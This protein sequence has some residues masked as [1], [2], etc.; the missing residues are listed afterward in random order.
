MKKALSDTS[1][2]RLSTGFTLVELLITIVLVAILARIVAP[3]MSSF[4]LNTRLTSASYEMTRSIQ[5]ARTEAIKRQSNVVL[6]T[7]ANPTAATPTCSKTGITGWI[8]FQDTNGNWD[9]AATEELI[10]THTFESS[11]MSLLA[12]N[13]M[14]IS[15]AVIGF[16]NPAGAKTPSTAIVMCDSR[17]NTSVSGQST[18]RGI[19]IAAGTGRAR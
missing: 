13:D 18:A 3:N 16:T 14:I 11:K 8:V 17:G 6:C 2:R 12:D 4:V 1:F 5:T 15:F 19:S 7:S 10:E 9:H